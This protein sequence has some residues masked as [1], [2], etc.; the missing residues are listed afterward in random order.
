MKILSYL[1]LDGHASPMYKSLIES[2]IGSEYAASTGYDNSTVRSTFSVGL[3][4]IRAEDV[5]LVSRTHL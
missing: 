2:N 1:I 4:G 5:C 3:Q